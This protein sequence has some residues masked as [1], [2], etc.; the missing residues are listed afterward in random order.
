MPENV[1]G[2]QGAS[3]VPE[4][5]TGPQDPQGASSRV[6]ERIQQLTR[7]RE[8]A[9]RGFSEARSELGSVRQEVEQLRELIQQSIQGGRQSDESGSPQSWGDVPTKDLNEALSSEFLQERPEMFR[10]ALEEKVRRMTDRAVSGALEKFGSGMQ[11]RQ[12]MRE[13]QQQVRS[14]IAREFGSEVGNPESE[15]YKA[16]DRLY[17]EKLAR[18]D[19]LYP[20]KGREMIERD[21]WS[22][23]DCFRQASIQ[24]GSV[25]RDKFEELSSQL[26]RQNRIRSM[27]SGISGA[28]YANNDRASDLKRGDV[29]SA[30]R[31]TGILRSFRED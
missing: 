12:T 29:K 22:E 3:P 19:Q 4:G 15:L 26:Q 23:Y 8:E 18:L 24:L 16:A 2:N 30:I 13:A 17:G 5:S 31:K 21:P 20:G 11:E 7:E 6:Q 28:L 9:K 1:V 14:Q 27:E 25:P 10:A